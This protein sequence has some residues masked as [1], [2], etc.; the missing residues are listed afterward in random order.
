M[1]SISGEQLV[2]LQGALSTEQFV[3]LGLIYNSLPQAPEPPPPSPD[4]TTPPVT[5]EGSGAP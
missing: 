3:A 4:A 5:P 1:D 2:A